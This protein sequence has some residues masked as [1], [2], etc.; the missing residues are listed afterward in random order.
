MNTVQTLKTLED[1]IN[2]NYPITFYPEVEGGYTVVIQDL[3]G[4]IST[5]ENLQEAMAVDSIKYKI[6]AVEKSRRAAKQD[7]S[8]QKLAEINQRIPL[9]KRMTQP[10]EIASMA[11]FLLS[12]KASHIT[13]QHLYVDG[14]YTHLDRSL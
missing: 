1:Y 10:E 12:E 9:G 11:I 8:A 7:K 2:L 13:G 4:C 3:S 14:G 5:G 6:Q